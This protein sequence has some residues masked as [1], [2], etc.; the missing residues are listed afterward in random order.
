MCVLFLAFLLGFLF[1]TLHQAAHG[2]ILNSSEKMLTGLS[3]LS[4]MLAHLLGL[5]CGDDMKD[6]LKLKTVGIMSESFSSCVLLL[7]EI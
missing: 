7:A 5:V 4:V 3:C 1:L 6:R 2:I